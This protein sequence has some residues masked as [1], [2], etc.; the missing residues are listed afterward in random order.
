MSQLVVITGPI[1]SGKS[2]V[3]DGLADHLQAVG[4]SAVSVDLDEVVSMLRAPL[5]RFERSWQQARVVHGAL[6]AAWLHAEV[7]VVIAHG[8]FYTDEETAALLDPVPPTIA[9]RRVMLLAPYE[10]ALARV[11][12]DARREASR[13]PNFLRS[14]HERFE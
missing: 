14:T 2:T 9:P 5:D 6:V 11:A 1:G 13:D 4:R 12:V 3:A 7:D 10:T 8:P